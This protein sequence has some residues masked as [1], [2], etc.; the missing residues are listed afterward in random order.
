MRK[1]FLIA[2]AVLVFSATFISLVKTGVTAKPVPEHRMRTKVILE[3]EERMF[4]E[5][6]REKNPEKF[7]K[8][9]ELK[10]ERPHLY[11]EILQRGIKEKHLMKRLKKE[12]PAR[13]E[14]KKEILQLRAKN[15]RLGREYRGCKFAKRKEEIRKEIKES[16]DRLFDLKQEENYC[17]ITEVEKKLKKLKKRGETRKKNKGKIINQRFN[18]II[19]KAED[20][21]WE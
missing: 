16:L 8:M 17:R 20:L 14:R 18:R 21:G 19:N 13:Y 15:W 4:M 11:L 7:E 2:A 1:K 3:G 12:D 5:Y 9:R 6:L 10:T